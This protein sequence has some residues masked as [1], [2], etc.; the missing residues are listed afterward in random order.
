[1][2]IADGK[3]TPEAG[4]GRTS[5]AQ[6]HPLKDTG[7]RRAEDEDEVPLN[8]IRRITARRLTESQSVPHFFPTSAVD[9]ERLFALRAE[10]PDASS[11]RVSG[12]VSTISSCEPAPWLCAHIPR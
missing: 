6:D 5:L 3:Q 1:M 2:A 8:S 10:M 12:S 9:V 4:A 11:P 7:D